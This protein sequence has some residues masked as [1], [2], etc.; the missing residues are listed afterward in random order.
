MPNLVKLNLNETNTK[1]L[2]WLADMNYNDAI[3]VC[4]TSGTLEVYVSQLS[5]PNNHYYDDLRHYKLFDGDDHD[6]TLLGT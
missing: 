1:H 3:S 5:S 6:G 4:A 2:V